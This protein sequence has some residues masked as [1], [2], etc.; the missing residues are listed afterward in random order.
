MRP[1][2]FVL[3]PMRHELK[4]FD[5]A[6]Q[7]SEKQLSR[8]LWLQPAELHIFGGRWSAETLPF[9]FGIVRRLPGNPFG[10][11]P[12]EDIR[13]WAAIREWSFAIARQIR[14][15]MVG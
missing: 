5:A 11:I 3:G 13:D 14:P 10:K 1:W 7:Q 6:R 2:C 4:D 12:G 9:P 8:Y 15:A